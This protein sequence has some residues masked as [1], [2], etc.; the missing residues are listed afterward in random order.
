MK[1]GHNLLIFPLKDVTKI[2]IVLCLMKQIQSNN[3]AQKRS[4]IDY[5]PFA[6]SPTAPVLFSRSDPARSTK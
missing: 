5:V 6:L 1:E 3:D 4:L 2:S